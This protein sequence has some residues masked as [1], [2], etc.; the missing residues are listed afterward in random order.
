M[1]D[2]QWLSAALFCASVL[3]VSCCGLVGHGPRRGGTRTTQLQSGLWCTEGDGKYDV[4]I[5]HLELPRGDF[6]KVLRNDDMITKAMSEVRRS[7]LVFVSD[8]TRPEGGGC[9]PDLARYISETY[10]RTWDEVVAGKKFDMQCTV[11]SDGVNMAVPGLEDFVSRYAPDVLYRPGSPRQPWS[12]LAATSVTEWARDPHVEQYSPLLR[13]E[14]DVSYYFLDAPDMQ[15]R[16]FS[17]VAVGG[18]FDRIH[19][20]HKKLL[21]FAALMCTEEL[22]VGVSGDALLKNKK[23]AHLIAPQTERMNNV[24]TFVEGFYPSLSLNIVP[25]D[26]PFGP[27]ITD[28]TIDAIIVSSETLGGAAKINAIRRARSFKP[29]D[30]IVSRRGET[31]TLSSTFLRNLEA[32]AA[33]L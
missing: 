9:S 14:E 26:D 28:A 24:R 22:T 32:D 3:G 8:S 21:T 30:V 2:K 31:S 20:G 17:K 10:S 12:P 13:T 25:I 1:M 23:G 4:G 6:E 29:L 18:T 33:R 15:L 7:L 27:T 19:H 16:T 5:L 11:V